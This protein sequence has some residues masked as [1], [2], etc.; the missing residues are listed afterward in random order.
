MVQSRA[1]DYETIPVFTSHYH[2]I[3]LSDI[4]TTC[5]VLSPV[6]SW[7]VLAEPLAPLLA[8]SDQ[9]KANWWLSCFTIAREREVVTV[10]RHN[11][12]WS[13]RSTPTSPGHWSHRDSPHCPHW[14]HC[15]QTLH[16][17]MICQ[18]S[19]RINS[20]IIIGLTPEKDFKSWD[21]STP[22]YSTI[23]KIYLV[24]IYMNAF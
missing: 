9:R 15:S 5:P 2:I 13:H 22:K 16:L 19:N 8:P 10:R 24:Q 4:L 3:R 1:A 18:S 17:I 12:M 23:I 7:A 14:R 20:N 21:I 11:L 6:L